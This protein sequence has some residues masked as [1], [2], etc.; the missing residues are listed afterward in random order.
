MAD[1]SGGEIDTAGNARF[2]S[3]FISE[4]VPKA[5]RGMMLDGDGRLSR[6]GEARI[7][8]ALF[9]LAYGDGYLTEQMA[10]ATDPD[11]RNKLRAMTGIAARLAA[12]N[13]D[14]KRGLLHELDIGGEIAEAYR[15]VLRQKM[16][17]RTVEEYLAQTSMLGEIKPSQKLLLAMFSEY[18]NSAKKM[19]G[20]LDSVLDALEEAGDP[21]QVGLLDVDVK[22]SEAGVISEGLRNFR[23]ELEEQQAASERFSLREFGFEELDKESKNNIKV[24]NDVVIETTDD[25]RYHIGRALMEENKNAKINLYIGA[26]NEATKAKIEADAK[27][28]LFKKAREYAFSVSYDD[29]QHIHKHFPSMDGTVDAIMRIYSM[30]NDHDSV[31]AYMAGNQQRMLLRKTFTDADY[32]TFN[33]VGNQRRV[34]DLVTVFI[35]KMYIKKGK[36]VDMRAASNNPG[37][38][39]QGSLSYNQNIP[40]TGPDSQVRKSERD[41]SYLAAVE[42]GDTRAAQEMVDEAARAAG[43]KV[44]AFYETKAEFSEFKPSKT[45][46]V[47][48]GAHFETE[49][50]A[51]DRNKVTGGENV[52]TVLL[53]IQNLFTS[54]DGSPMTEPADAYLE[55]IA[56]DRAVAI[57]QITHSL[58]FLFP[59]INI[60]ILDDEN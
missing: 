16:T 4:V 42:K 18:K 29:I 58:P 36:R 3:R 55:P 19:T 44:A 24:R 31:E 37:S 45:L 23:A 33:I 43:Y 46:K 6:A 34:V 15:T 35:S 59:G 54:R 7:R 56:K 30:L 28:T 10:E 17:G 49:N 11:S 51:Q 47:A 20:A 39:P 21:R 40:E 26:I 5:E 14:M 9:Q 8:N 48:I 41:R 50:A 25:L 22:P 38:P 60:R 1:M 53:N 52:M 27:T 32:T 2:I 13:A 57:L 12:M